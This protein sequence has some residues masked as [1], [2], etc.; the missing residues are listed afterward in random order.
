MTRY[1]A[2][3]VDT[4]GAALARYDLRATDQESAEQEAKQY[5]AQHPA[6]EVWPDDHRRVSRLKR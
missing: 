3:A 2:F 1:I 4:S 6:I 5:L